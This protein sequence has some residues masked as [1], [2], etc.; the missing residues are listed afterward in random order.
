MEDPRIRVLQQNSVLR[1]KLTLSVRDR[2]RNVIESVQDLMQVY[3][4]EH[5]VLRRGHK[6]VDEAA[7][8]LGFIRR[9]EQYSL[10]FI[11]V[12]QCK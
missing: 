5:V 7:V 1:V 9:M 6:G 8:D 12:H 10:R 2:I 3:E 11:C 4:R